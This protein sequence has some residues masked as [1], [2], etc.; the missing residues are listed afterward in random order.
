MKKIFIY[1]LA[2][3]YWFFFGFCFVLGGGGGGGFVLFY[4]VAISCLVLDLSFD[5]EPV[6]HFAHRT[7]SMLL[8][9]CWKWATPR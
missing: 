3:Y 1:N 2:I 6:E 4:V 9:D 5:C 8:F 7:V